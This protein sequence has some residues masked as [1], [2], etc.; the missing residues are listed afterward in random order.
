MDIETFVSIDPEAIKSQRPPIRLI[1][2]EAVTL[3]A[4]SFTQA[5]LMPPTVHRGD[6]HAVLVLPA[7][8]GGDPYTAFVRQFLTSVGYS[9]HGWNLGL[10]VGPTKRLPE[11]A[12]Y[13]VIELTVA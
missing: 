9:A 11:G 7:L 8:L 13:R 10:N 4:T 12:S 1:A 5:D 6:G 3:I 2:A